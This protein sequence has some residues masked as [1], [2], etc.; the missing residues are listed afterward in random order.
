MPW[1]TDLKREIEENHLDVGIFTLQELY[2]YSYNNLQLKYPK[3]KTIKYSIQGTLQVLRDE[4][5]LL[6][7]GRGEYKVLSLE[8]DEFI[9]FVNVYHES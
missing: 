5:Y 2:R 6:F 1:K 9:N 8:N 7:L 4:K 3:N